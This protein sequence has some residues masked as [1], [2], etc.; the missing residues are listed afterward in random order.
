MIGI[1]YKDFCVIKGNL[2]GNIMLIVW[3]SAWCFIPWTKIMDDLENV[4]NTSYG[5][6]FFLVPLLAYVVTAIV[7]SSLATEVIVQ[8]EDKYYS[9]FISS[10]PMTAKGQILCKYYEILLL[11]FFVVLWGYILDTVIS[12][13]NGVSGSSM[14]IYIPCFFFLIFTKA[15]ETPFLIRYGTKIGKMVKIIGMVAMLY[16]VII[17][18]LFGPLPD[19]NSDTVFDTIINWFLQDK[20]FSHFTSGVIALTP[21]LIMV[22][23][24]ISYKVSCKWYQKGVNSYDT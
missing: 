17:Y 24:Y 20:N 10:T 7:L 14:M 1:M 3:M 8:D 15:I 5:I 19:I 13:I 9:A 23:F 6:S 16:G 11:S 21:Y 22:M 4:G 2:L 12:L 18:L